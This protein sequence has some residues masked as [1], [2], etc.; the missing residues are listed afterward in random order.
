MGNDKIR[1]LV[2]V[3]GRWRWRPT[4]SMRAAGFRMINLG[5]GILEGG[6]SRPSPEDKAKA[7]RLNEA[8]GGKFTAAH[9]NLSA[10][11]NRT[12]D[13][14]KALEYARAAIALDPESDR[15]WFQ[16]A[17]A[18]EREGRLNDAVAAA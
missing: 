17:K 14:A 9:V 11:F 10:H 1:Y 3:N 18:D 15:A 5:P 6:R 16:K 2:F 8:K 7:I 4:K 13:P 12:G